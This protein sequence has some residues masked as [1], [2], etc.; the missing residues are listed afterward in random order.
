VLDLEDCKLENVSF[1]LA[2]ADPQNN[3]IVTA[4]GRTRDEE[5]FSLFT[6]VWVLRRM[7]FKVPTQYMWWPKAPEGQHL[8]LD[9]ADVQDCAL[10]AV[11]DLKRHGPA[12]ESVVHVEGITHD[13]QPFDLYAPVSLVRQIADAAGAGGS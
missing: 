8:D 12:G 5:T 10:L 4:Q 13:G 6:P 7:L 3:S 2:E 1:E 9:G 11:V